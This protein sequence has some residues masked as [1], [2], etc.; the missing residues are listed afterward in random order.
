MPQKPS[1]SRVV[2]DA[3]ADEEDEVAMNMLSVDSKVAPL[4][5]M[6]VSFGDDKTTNLWILVVFAAGIPS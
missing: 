1:L 3:P 5:R 4:A 6:M 2:M